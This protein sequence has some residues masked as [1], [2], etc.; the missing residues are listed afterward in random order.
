MPTNIAIVG[1]IHTHWDESDVAW[2]DQSD[3]DLIVVVG[4][5]AGFRFAGTLAIAELVGTLKTPTI[6]VPGNH[7]ATH[8]VQ[9]LGES[10]QHPGMGLPF[11]GGQG[12][13]LQALREAMH[14]H[15]LGAYSL[16][17]VDGLTVLAARPHSMGGPSLAFA[18]HLKATWGV[19]TLQQSTDRLCALV[20][21]VETDRIVFV[22]HNGPAGLGNRRSDIWGC[23][24]KK[25]E[26][27]W[28]DL[29]LQT[30]I[31]YAKTAGKRV[32]AVAAGHM[33][34]R[35]KRGGER[36]SQLELDGTVYINSAVVPRISREGR[37][38]HVRLSITNGIARAT[39]QW[40]KT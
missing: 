19:E 8:A 15:P 4:D 28:G 10:I 12:R 13:N 11:V 32:V 1:D 35:L 20:D 26:G 3:Y 2:F 34:R 16:H 18:P 25:E 9:M 5:L 27:D 17:P 31:T 23:D 6:L 7:D 38:H 24:F 14:P 21:E 36:V 40:A 29:D 33:H 30:A 22:A 39:D 37:R